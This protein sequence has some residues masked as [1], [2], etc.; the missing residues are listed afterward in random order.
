MHIF[1]IDNA[2]YILSREKRYKGYWSVH[3]PLNWKFMRELAMEPSSTHLESSFL[4]LRRTMNSP[5]LSE[6]AKVK[7]W[8]YLIGLDVKGNARS[9]FQRNEL[10]TSQQ[11]E[12]SMDGSAFIAFLFVYS[13]HGKTKLK[14]I[15]L[16]MFLNVWF[17]DS[18]C[19]I[20]KILETIGIS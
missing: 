11:D 8:S 9:A 3:V 4:R 6:I 10:H 17:Y 16:S 12:C 18:Q 14:R 20:R 1:Y 7:F 2:T 13:N 15:I 19:L 5:Q